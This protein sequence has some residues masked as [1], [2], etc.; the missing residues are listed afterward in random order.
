MMRVRDFELMQEQRR[1][2]ARRV[3]WAA[4]WLLAGW[5]VLERSSAPRREPHRGASGFHAEDRP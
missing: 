4:L 2:T 3:L 5:G 1:R